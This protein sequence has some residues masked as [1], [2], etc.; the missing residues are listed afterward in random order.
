[1]ITALAKRYKK[2][3]PSAQTIIEDTIELLKKEKS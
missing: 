3:L 1:M 2:G